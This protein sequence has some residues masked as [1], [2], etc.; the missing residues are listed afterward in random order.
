MMKYK[1]KKWEDV[2]TG[3][4]I[5]ISTARDVEFSI[6]LSNFGKPKALKI[7]FTIMAGP[8]GKVKRAS[9]ESDELLIK[10]KKP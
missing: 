3:N 9:D 5:Y 1:N 10:I 7:R 4:D 6:P 2:R 8:K